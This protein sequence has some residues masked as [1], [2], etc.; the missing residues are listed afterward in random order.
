[1]ASTEVLAIAKWPSNAHLIADVAR[2]GYLQ[3]GWNILDATYG[4]GGFW[5]EWRPRWLF[6]NDNDPSTNADWHYDFCR[7]P[8]LWTQKF[9]AVVFDPPYKL[10][11]TPDPALDKRYGVHVARRWQDRMADIAAGTRECARVSKSMLLVKCQDQVCSGAMRWQTDL[12]RDVAIASGFGKV[13][14]FDYISGGR[15]QPAG[16]RQVH[17][18]HGMASQLLIFKRGHVS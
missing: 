7:L 2:L 12:V 13:E 16:R 9:D 3:N 1:M 8:S 17:A 14:R 10:N 18:R 11:G 15:P 4:Q 6:T 5:T